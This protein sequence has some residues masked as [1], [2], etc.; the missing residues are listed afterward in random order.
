MIS[1]SHSSVTRGV[2]RWA[3]FSRS[4]LTDQATIEVLI[5][6][7]ATRQFEQLQLGDRGHR[8]EVEGIEILQDRERRAADSGFE[9]LG[10]A[11]GDLHFGQA[12]KI[13]RVIFVGR[14]GLTGQL[15]ELGTDRRQPELLQIRLEQLGRRIGHRMALQSRGIG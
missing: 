6:P 5:D 13:L 2:L 1:P 8:R 9:P 3:R 15:R 10:R 11:G 12:Q 7:L 4:G 14:G